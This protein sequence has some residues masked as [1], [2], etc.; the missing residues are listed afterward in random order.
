MLFL[1]WNCLHEIDQKTGFSE[2]SVMENPSFTSYFVTSIFL[3]F[4][5]IHVARV[6][7]EL[8]KGRGYCYKTGQCSKSCMLVYVNSLLFCL[9]LNFFWPSNFNF[10]DIWSRMFCKVLDIHLRRLIVFKSLLCFI[11]G[12]VQGYLLL[13]PTEYKPSKQGFQFLRK[14]HGLV[15]DIRCL[16][17]CE[18]S[19]ILL[20]NWGMNN[21]QKGQKNERFLSI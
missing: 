19:V 9:C 20:K 1:E 8:C 16:H 11:G 3:V 4:A 14:L 15:E 7:S 12:K 10:V 18:L 5:I 2:S 13:P 21:L 17:Y 6:W